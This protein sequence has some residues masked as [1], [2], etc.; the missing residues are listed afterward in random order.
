M[1]DKN[2]VE[3]HDTV[4]EIKLQQQEHKY[5]IER[6]RDDLEKLASSITDLHDAVRPVVDVME[7]VAAVGRLGKRLKIVMLW[8]VSAGAVIAAGYEWL[9][10]LGNLKSN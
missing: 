1:D 8:F 9:Q 10:H 2:I 3:I 5:V 6:N 4:Q 7:D